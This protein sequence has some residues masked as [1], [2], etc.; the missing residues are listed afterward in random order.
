M[1][2]AM[3]HAMPHTVQPTP[4]AACSH[5]MAY[6]VIQRAWHGLSGFCTAIVLMAW[7]AGLS[8]AQAHQSSTAYLNIQPAAEGGVAQYRL[9]IRDLAVLV[10]LDANQDRIIRWG[11]IQAQQPAIVTLLK[12]AMHWQAANRTCGMN[13]L[14]QPFAI[15]QIAGMAYLVMYLSIDCGQ[16]PFDQLDYQVLAG[17]DKDHRLIISLNPNGA[18]SN[19]AN[20]NGANPNATAAQNPAPKARTWLISS[21]RVALRAENTSP[22]TTVK[23]YLSEGIHHLLTGYDHLLFLFCL[24][25]TTVYYRADKQWLPVQ[26]ARTAMR[27]TLYIATAFTVAHSITLTLAVLKIVILPAQW[28]ESIIAFSIALAALHNLFPVFGAQQIRIAFLFGLVH[29]FGFASVLS[30]LPLDNWSRGLAL[31]SF[32]LGIELGQIGCVLLFFPLALVLRHTMFYRAIVFQ[33]GSA[34]ACLL[35]LIWMIQRMLGFGWIAG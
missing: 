4:Q 30:E 19:G 29:G 6:A 21:G 32:N 10:P 33:A 31:L 27:H 12:Q 15:E 23:T 34:L 14:Q 28:V 16:Q 2:H 9:A 18:N 26:S 13:A 5:L 3:Q 24:L 17:I 22:R 20:P 25:V 11:E 7:L 8:A 35:A 1:Q